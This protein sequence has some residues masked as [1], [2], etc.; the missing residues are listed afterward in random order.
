MMSNETDA[1]ARAESAD[2]PTADRIP[3]KEDD[4]VDLAGY[5]GRPQAVES[6]HPQATMREKAALD[7]AVLAA[8]TGL[9]PDGETCK[10][11]PAGFAWA[12]NVCRVAPRS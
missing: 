4:A 6:N 8:S 7:G 2:M 12:C 10:L 3:P 1:V 11:A 5:P 9:I